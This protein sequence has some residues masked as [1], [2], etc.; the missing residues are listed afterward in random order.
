MQVSLL[1]MIAISGE[2]LTAIIWFSSYAL[3]PRIYH[4]GILFLAYFI[5]VC[6]MLFAFYQAYQLTIAGKMFTAFCT[7]YSPFFTS[8]L[9]TVKIMLAA[10][11][12]LLYVFVLLAYREKVGRFAG[13]NNVAI[14]MS[15]TRRLTQT[16]ALITSCTLIFYCIPWT[17][18]VILNSVGIFSL[19]S[20]FWVFLPLQYIVHVLVFF[21]RQQE[22]RN[23]IRNLVCCK[24]DA[25]FIASSNANV[26]MA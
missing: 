22:V 25:L 11:S 19:N 23:S 6:T 20:H 13:Q 7:S 10:A 16:L 9:P 18:V 1:M 12:V 3:I 17:V 26:D 15:R 5:P 2:R 8:V 4:F 21:W 14:Q 24:A